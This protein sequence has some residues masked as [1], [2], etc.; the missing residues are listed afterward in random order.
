MEGY[1]LGKDMTEMKASLEHLHRRLDALILALGD[2]AKIKELASEL[3]QS[4]DK[5][6]QAATEVPK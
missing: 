3:G 6:Q 2:N 4:T 1:Q 5:L